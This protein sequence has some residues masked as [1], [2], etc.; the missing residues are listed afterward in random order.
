MFL[1][2]C[3][4]ISA[5]CTDSLLATCSCTEREMQMPPT[6][7]RLSRRA[8]MLT[9]SPSR[10]PSRST[11]SPMVMP[12]RKI[13]LP[14]R[15]I[16]HVARAQALLDVDCTAHGFHRAREFREHG[17][18]C[19]VEDPPTCF[20]NEI[21]RDGAVGGQTSQRLFLVLGYQPRIAGNIGGKDRGNLP[22]HKKAA[23][24][25]NFR[26]A[27]C[28]QTRCGATGFRRRRGERLRR[29]YEGFSEGGDG[30]SIRAAHP[31]RRAPLAPQDDGSGKACQCIP[32]VLGFCS[33]LLK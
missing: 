4:P 10:S 7:A 26:A 1:T 27:E 5:N 11:T 28:R 15:R 20:R 22:F 23:P 33:M 24:D 25:S 31:S 3:S 12:M 19:S 9:P 6:S 2:S 18:A 29:D 16:G 13:H 32:V 8:A 30:C 21:V 17:I 14:A